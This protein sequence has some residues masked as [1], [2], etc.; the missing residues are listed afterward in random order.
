MGPNLTK[1]LE[2][3]IPELLTRVAKQEVP[4]DTG[5]LRDSL[6]PAGYTRR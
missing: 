4:V 1:A 5:A 2:E 3:L 6:K